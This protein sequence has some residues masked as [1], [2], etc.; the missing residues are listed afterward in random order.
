[1]YFE[2]EFISVG[3]KIWIGFNNSNMCCMGA[4][5]ALRSRG[6]LHIILLLILN[7]ESEDWLELRT[8]QPVLDGHLTLQLVISAVHLQHPPTVGWCL[9]RP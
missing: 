8:L 2:G 1:M 9:C 4:I 3:G 6:Q 5:L 7:M